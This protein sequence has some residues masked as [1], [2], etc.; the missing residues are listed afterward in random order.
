LSPP[1]KNPPRQKKKKKK[2]KKKNP[3]KLDIGQEKGH[4][5]EKGQTE[6]TLQVGGFA[7]KFAIW[8][9][10]SLSLLFVNF[11]LFNPKRIWKA[12]A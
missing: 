2:K 12:K 8:G 4:G 9:P 6:F 11:A 7:F 5:K 3:I 10:F 1:K